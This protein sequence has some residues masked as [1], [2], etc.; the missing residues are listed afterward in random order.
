MP[1][2]GLIHEPHLRAKMGEE[3]KDSTNKMEEVAKIVSKADL[4]APFSVIDDAIV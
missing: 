4:I 1:Q 3:T 2:H